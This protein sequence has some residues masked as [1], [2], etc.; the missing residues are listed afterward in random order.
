VLA[1]SLLMLV[2]ITSVGE[3]AVPFA[4]KQARNLK[5][6]AVNNY[7]LKTTRYGL[8]LRR[9]NN[10]IYIKSIEPGKALT[11]VSQYVFDNDHRLKQVIYSA[12]AFRRGS[13]WF[14]QDIHETILQDTST[15]SQ[16]VAERPWSIDLKPALLE[17]SHDDANEMTLPQLRRVIGYRQLSGLSTEHYAL[18]YWQR[19][20]QPFATLI[21]I[22]LGIPFIFGPLRTVTM[23][24]RILSGAVV[25]FSFYLA[26]QF[27]GPISLVYQVPAFV[28]AVLPSC[29]FLMVGVFLLAR[30]RK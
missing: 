28:G 22:F 9:G 29:L 14:L 1:A 2:V 12:R 15:L 19:V 20:F 18:A 6:L 16:T 26:N 10:F 7:Q 5:T 3:L 27:F 13:Q 30:S 11:D 25:G 8:W 24:V 21:M 17:V 23:G 4:N